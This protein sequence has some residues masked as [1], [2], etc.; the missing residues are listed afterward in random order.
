MT[1]DIGGTLK[2]TNNISNTYEMVPIPSVTSIKVILSYATSQTSNGLSVLV[3]RLDLSDT[4]ST[5]V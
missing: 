1:L 4:W 3:V 5:V 2:L